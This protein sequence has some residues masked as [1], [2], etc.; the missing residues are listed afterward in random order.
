M[1]RIPFH[2][3]SWVEASQDS[4]S[5]HKVHQDQLISHSRAHPHAKRLSPQ[6]GNLHCHLPNKEIFGSGLISP[7]GSLYVSC[8]ALAPL[9][10]GTNF[11]IWVTKFNVHFP[12]IYFHGS[13]PVFKR[14]NFLPFLALLS[15]PSLQF[16]IT[17]WWIITTSGSDNILVFWSWLDVLIPA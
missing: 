5:S 4:N 14:G 7:S 3:Q 13:P 17:Q 15:S 16:L 1:V 10:A 11:P 2:K 8:A 12:S 9:I 6:C